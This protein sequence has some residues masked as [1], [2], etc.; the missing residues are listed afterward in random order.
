VLCTHFARHVGACF[1]TGGRED[2]IGS[3]V[4]DTDETVAGRAPFRVGGWLVEPSLNR[5]SRGDSAVRLDFKAMELLVF[6]AEH[7]GE[8]L[9][10]RR[11][12]DSVWKIE[13][14]ADGTLT[15]AIAQLR[16]SLGDSARSP[17]FIETIPKRGYRLIAPV[18]MTDVAVPVP[19]HDAS[20]F[21]LAAH[22]GETALAEGEN[23][24]GRDRTAVVRIDCPGVSRRH[25]RILIEGDTAVLED[26][27]S[28]NGTFLAGRQLVQPARLSHGDEI[29]IGQSVAR[30]TLVV[31]DSPTS[32]RD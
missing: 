23:L 4:S 13:V 29:R 31:E 17:T 26:L 25:A 9:S 27:G 20:R 22:D 8:V 3:E 28:K 7:A 24:I 16:K 14:I 6:L 21:R 18:R 19:R 11:L 15:H 30:F 1:A 12:V 32:S 2:Y 5:L 10:K